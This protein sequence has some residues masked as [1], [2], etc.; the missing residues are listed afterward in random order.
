M[1]TKQKYIRNLQFSKTIFKNAENS[2]T[3][4]Y[5]AERT[6]RI[7]ARASGVLQ[8]ERDDMDAR[9]SK[10]IR[11]H[12]NSFIL[13][14]FAIYIGLVENGI[15]KAEAIAFVSSELNKSA[16]RE[17]ELLS[18]FQKLP[19]AY[20]LLRLL[21]KPVIK[22]GFPKEGWTV[23]WKENSRKRIAFDMTSCLY[24]EELTKRNA[25]ELCPVF[26]ETDVVS[27]RP[28]APGI[29]FKRK[30]NLAQQDS[31]VCDFCFEKGI[32]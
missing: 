26:C 9:G 11:K 18:K 28:M 24:Y 7:I 13:P 10:A 20:T 3:S 5:G 8:K 15:E 6:S 1:K 2:L 25:L 21:V 27:Y 31:K 16:S 32:K 12:L 23:I 14:G 17:G 22:F 30:G 4:A 29:V 19:L